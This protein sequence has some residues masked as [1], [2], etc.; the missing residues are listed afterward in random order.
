MGELRVSSFAASLDVYCIPSKINGFLYVHNGFNQYVCENKFD[1]VSLNQNFLY[2]F[3]FH[4]KTKN[5]SERASFKKTNENFLKIMKLCYYIFD[6]FSPVIE[7]KTVLI[8]NKG[9]KVS[10]EFFPEKQK[11]LIEKIKKEVSNN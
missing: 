7:G 8:D 4:E 2:V 10:T 6:M 3:D 5:S 1:Y 9:R 11:E